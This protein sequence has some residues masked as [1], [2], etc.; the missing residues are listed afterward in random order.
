MT[1]GQIM[2]AAG[3]KINIISGKNM[4]DGRPWHESHTVQQLADEL[5]ALKQRS[6]SLIHAHTPTSVEA[7]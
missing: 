5:K 3:A 6:R 2:E 7:S 4:V 1:V